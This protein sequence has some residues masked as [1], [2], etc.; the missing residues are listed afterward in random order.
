MHGAAS[1]AEQ[2]LIERQDSGGRW[3]FPCYRWLDPD[4]DDLCPYRTLVPRDPVPFA[5]GDAAQRGA[6]PRYLDGIYD[7]S[8]CLPHASEE[9][10]YRTLAARGGG[11]TFTESLL[12]AAHANAP[13]ADLAAML[14][15][16][17]AVYEAL[18]AAWGEIDDEGDGEPDPDDFG[19][20]DEELF[21]VMQSWVLRRTNIRPLTNV[22]LLDVR[23]LR[24]Y[25]PEQG[26]SLWVDTTLRLPNEKRPLP[27]IGRC[28]L[29][30]ADTEAETEPLFVARGLDLDSPVIA[31]E[32]SDASA[33]RDGVLGDGRSVALIE[34][35]SVW[36]DDAGAV[37]TQCVA[38][39]VLPL[40]LPTTGGLCRY[41]NSGRFQVPLF[42]GAQMPPASLVCT[43]GESGRADT[44]GEAAIARAV[45]A[46]EVKP[47]DGASLFVRVVD[48]QLA[49]VSNSDNLSLSFARAW[50][51]ELLAACPGTSPLACVA[52]GHDAAGHRARQRE[53]HGPSSIGTRRLV[54]E[55]PRLTLLPTAPR[56]RRRRGL[57]HCDP[58]RNPWKHS[59]DDG[60]AFWRRH[61]C[62]EHTRA[63]SP[64]GDLCQPKCA[65]PPRSAHAR[66]LAP[67][68]ASKKN[69]DS[70]RP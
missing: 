5:D 2:V 16:G 33:S 23:C 58:K 64:R 44:M 29:I 20:A 65:P 12:S 21:D 57:R 60:V 66:R 67:R 28:S 26:L 39:A 7:S 32:W 41:L 14:S 34:I 42:H 24:A 30:G 40:F 55:P 9:E 51:A 37:Q 69:Q 38:W 59:S 6:L 63:M 11:G 10:M 53:I 15:D 18:P 1:C 49:P 70:F 4:K 3:Q 19:Y 27:L 46:K 31:P 13:T 45:K 68:P 43:I 48:Q 22:P 62:N 17:R 8:L 47:L 56:E 35:A 61:Q 50:G 54:S 36:E 52:F 25:N